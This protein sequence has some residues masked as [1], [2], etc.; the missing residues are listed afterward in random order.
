M[1]LFPP[2]IPRMHLLE[3]H[4]EPWCPEVFRLFVQDILRWSWESM[5]LVQTVAPLLGEVC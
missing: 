3:I 4:E 1:K 5:G 2:R